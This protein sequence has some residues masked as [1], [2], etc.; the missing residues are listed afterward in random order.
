MI[1]SDDMD[2]KFYSV[3]QIS[4][5]LNMHTKTI[6]RYI[7]EGKLPATKIG[8]AWRVSGHDLSVFVQGSN[9]TIEH[10]AAA[11]K[12]NP[13]DRIMISSI[14]DID[15][16]DKNEGMNIAN[17]LTAALNNKPPEYGKSTMNAQFIEDDQMLRITL[18]GNIQFM[19]AMM[20]FFAKYINE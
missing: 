18:W 9:K 17:M 7:R 15:V 2:N 5:M 14:V 6:Q 8:K 12:D 4:Q 11:A 19:K 16:A 1:W 3:E 10:K 20:W 13:N